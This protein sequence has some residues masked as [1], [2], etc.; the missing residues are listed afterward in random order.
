[1][2]R[3]RAQRPGQLPARLAAATMTQR[4]ALPGICAVRAPVWGMRVSVAAVSMV[5]SMVVAGTGTSAGWLRQIFGIGGLSDSGHDSHSLGTLHTL[6][7]HT[8]VFDTHTHNLNYVTSIA[9]LR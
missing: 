4:A 7:C 8:L 5:Q 6:A 9:Y 3:R 1:M 2:G